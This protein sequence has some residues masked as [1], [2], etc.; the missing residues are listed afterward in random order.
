MLI[1]NRLTLII[2]LLQTG[3][4]LQPHRKGIKDGQPHLDGEYQE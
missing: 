3:Q 2:L 1:F 4:V